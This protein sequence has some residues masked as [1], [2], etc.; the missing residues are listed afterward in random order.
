MAVGLQAP[1]SS[2]TS[3]WHLT[4][5][6]TKISQVSEPMTAIM[7]Y[8]YPLPPAPDVDVSPTNL[9]NYH[10]PAIPPLHPQPVNK[11]GPVRRGASGP[12]KGGKVKRSASSPNVRG[13]ARTDQ[14][15]SA[16]MSLAD[17]KRRN[18]LGY[19]RTSVACGQSQPVWLNRFVAIKKF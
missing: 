11:T 12:S 8:Q 13:Q 7:S 18:K 9:V 16:F 1:I 6:S 10:L 14:T 15:E 2:K 19:H 17:E 5:P 3:A 4:Q